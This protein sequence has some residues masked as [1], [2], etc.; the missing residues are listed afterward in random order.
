M[1][2]PEVAKK[3]L[4]QWLVAVDEDDDD[5]LQERLLPKVKKLPAKL[6]SIGYALLDRDASGSDE[7]EDWEARQT[8]NRQ[9]AQS[10]DRLSARDRRDLFRLFFGP[11][12][13]AVETTWQW[14]KGAPYVRGYSETPFRA[15]Q[16]PEVTLEGRDTWLRAMMRLMKFQ[17][18]VLTPA[19]LAVWAPYIEVG[20]SNLEEEIGALLA[21]VIDAGGKQG[22]EVFEILCQSARKEHEIGA[23]G[24]HAARALLAA[25]RSEG[26]ELMEKMLLAA[27]RQEGLRQV[28]LG[29]VAAAHPQAFRR[30]LRLIVG[31]GLTRFSSVVRAVDIWLGLAW[32]SAGGKKVNDTIETL[33]S[34]LEKPAERKKALAGKDAET[35]YLA[36]WAIAF[37]D[38]PASIKPAESLL[39]HK[40]VEMR[41]IAVLH[42]A[43]IGLPAARAGRVKALDDADL[44]VALC[45][46]EGPLHDPDI[47]TDEL[48]DHS[49]LFETLEGLVV[50]MPAKPVKLKPLVWPWTERVARRDQVSGRL[51]T[52]LGEAPPT[53]LLPHLAVLDS[54]DRSQLAHALAGQKKWDA[55]TRDALLNLAGDGASDVRSS[56]FRGLKKA[57]LTAA[58]IERLEGY[59]T[60]SATD[61]RNEVVSLV[62]AMPDKEAFA[63]ASRLLESGNQNQRLAGLEVVRQLAV[64][65][66]QRGRCIEL[67]QAWRDGRKQ[68]LKAEQTQLD[69]ILDSD[70]VTFTLDNALG[71]MNPAGRTQ[72][73]APKKR[74]VVCTS[75][76]IPKILKSLDD[77]V[78]K[79]REEKVRY[80]S[81]RGKEEEELLGEMNYGFPSPD[82]TKP[83]AAQAERLPLRE[84]WEEWYRTRPAALK[85][86]DGLELLRTYLFHKATGDYSYEYEELK[87][88]AK[89]SPSGKAIL[90]FAIGKVTPPKLKYEGLIDD[91]LDWLLVLYPPKGAMDFLLDGLET[92]A[93]MISDKDM[94][95]IRQRP[96]K[97]DEDDDDEE[98]WRSTEAIGMWHGAIG[99]F[100]DVWSMTPQQKTRYWRFLRWLDEPF[101]GAKRSRPSFDQL[102][103]AYLAK[104]A[105]FDDVVDHLLGPRHESRYSWRGGFDSWQEVTARQMSKPRR[106]FAARPEVAE[107]VRKACDTLLEIELARGEAATVSSR[108]ALAVG[109]Y[110]GIE[111]LQ[112]LLIAL[113]KNGFKKLTGW[114]SETHESRAATFTELASNTFP[115]E[116]E[117]PEQF[118]QV[119]RA[120]IDAGHFPE[121][122]LLQLA[123]LAPQWTPFVEA[124]IGWP[125]LAEGLYWF[126]A[127]M[128]YVWGMEKALEE[129]SDAADE[130]E[131]AD[132][133]DDDDSQEAKPRKLSRWERLILERTSLT[134]EERSEG[135]IDVAWFHRTHE[136]LSPK[137]WE[138]L[139]AAA[140]FAATGAQ[141][142]RA[143]FIAD[144]LLGKA[145]KKDLIDG[146]RKKNLKENVRLLGLLPLEKGA[147]REQDIAQRYEVL[148]G[149]RRYASGL[150]SM[151]RPEALRACDI[152]LKN[153]A[154][155]AGYADPVR[156]QWAMEAESTKDLAKGPVSVTKGDVSMTLALDS[157]ARPEVTVRRGEKVIKSLPTAL[158][159]DKTFAELRERAAQLK[160]QASRVKQSLEAAMCRGDT[161]TGAEL[162]QLADH[163]LLWPQLSRLVLI[164][165]GIAGYPV[166]GG[167]ALQDYAGKL[168]PVKKQETLRI[169]HPH[170][171]LQLK[172]WDR[173]QHECF[174][175]ERLQPFKQVFRE[176]YV[177]TA[178]E[179][180]DEFVSRRYAGQQVNP[181]QAHA[182]WGRRGWSVDEYENVWRAFHDEGL[183]ATVEFNFGFTTP[184]EVEGLTINTLQF[185]RRDEYKPLKLTDVPPRVFS[186]VMRDMDLVVSVAHA[187]EVDPEASAS[188]VEMRAS[189]LRE[190]CDLL[191]LKN[192]ELRDSRALVKGNLGEY[193]IHL[194]SGV[195]HRMPGGS[196]CIV[197][198]HSQHRGRLFLPFADDDPRTAEVISKTILLA[199]DQEIDDP[200]IL[201]QL[202]AMA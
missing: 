59:L 141:A 189:L 78:H 4:E 3:Q 97:A 177:V 145:K 116:G 101:A 136:Q 42:L 178:Q 37:D 64:A 124:A 183:N 7:W 129:D 89:K 176:L 172:A 61:L 23:F 43:R 127:H 2:K 9:Q 68:V 181:R 149:Y 156:L 15:P 56:A 92:V 173:W 140:K 6:R 40:N 34:L 158:G 174:H 35:A 70:K 102:A 24:K 103:G 87:E 32:A 121:D 135:A 117:T 192:V 27:Q 164:G 48:E 81:W 128:R 120:A 106:A 83:A 167:K 85:D 191:N 31:E 146:V 186:E 110:R 25:S 55:A 138:A 16:S 17:S 33:I 82:F 161:F 147:K 36:L 29:T 152:G 72:P 150:S 88:W 151:S 105:S 190:T 148:Q 197:P 100:E 73:V 18:D 41:Y 200:L 144:V 19:W 13:D 122:R 143:Q 79:H 139:A 14:M 169:A 8:F 28:I 46:L 21:A 12:A 126:M 1:L 38:A 50:R 76:V 58:D 80:K 66:R 131:D 39:G 165:E 134:D 154:A 185:H 108:A 75:P 168:E 133:D 118:A 112:R 198:I 86:K 99:R 119:M 160:R 137:R 93:A 49:K 47:D 107:F 162:M 166:K 180:A 51:L 62:I 159:K 115:A 123:F 125:G 182:L 53:R 69:A 179:K 94:E 45:A 109:A 195:V 57:K 96:A 60:R 11:L 201:E 54:G 74:K 104:D 5:S 170:D 193:S 175:A 130:A 84:V 184:L 111:T 142:K 113:G 20:W 187:G 196:V 95:A 157:D 63:S 71:L 22:D 188:T 114:R 10:L 26:W 132:S 163:A 199:R 90:E 65:D 77:L 30:M 194:G 155:T 67:A 153:L 52:S 202:R 98:D 91:L 171:L 44:R